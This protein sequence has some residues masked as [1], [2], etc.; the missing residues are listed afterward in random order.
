VLLPGEIVEADSSFSASVASLGAHGAGPTRRAACDALAANV[1]E[2]AASQHPLDGFEVDVTED[3]ESTVYV[4]SN[5]PARLVSLLLRHQRTAHGMSLA[6]VADTVGA[7]SKNS[8]A[9]YEQGRTEPSIGK[10][11][12]LLV[13]VAPEYRLA[14]IP[15]T[16]AVIP[17]HDEDE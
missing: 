13:V 14:I 8:Y 5:D 12:E 16:A 15:R 10:L 6:D 7:K 9:T 11:Q 3:G 2:I 4:T 17:R 1:L